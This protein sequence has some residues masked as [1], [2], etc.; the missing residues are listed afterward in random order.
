[1]YGKKII[2]NLKKAADKDTIE[3]QKGKEK[4]GAEKDFDLQIFEYL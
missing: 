2:K 4:N 3:Y 1:M